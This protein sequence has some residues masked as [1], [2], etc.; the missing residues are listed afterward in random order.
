MQLD[1][2][3]LRLLDELIRQ[4]LVLLIDRGERAGVCNVLIRFQRAVFADG[5]GI[6]AGEDTETDRD[7]IA[8]RPALN[9]AVDQLAIG[10]SEADGAQ[11]HVFQCCGRQDIAPA[12][13]TAA[14][15][16]LRLICGRDR[17]NVDALQPVGVRKIRGGELIFRGIIDGDLRCQRRDA[18]HDQNQRC[19]QRGAK[20]ADAVF[21]RENLLHDVTEV[22]SASGGKICKQIE[23]IPPESPEGSNRK[24]LGIK[25]VDRRD[26]LLQNRA[27]RL[28]L[29]LRT[30]CRAVAAAA[31]L[32][33]NGL[34]IARA[35]GTRADNDLLAVREEYK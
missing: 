12:D 27:Q 9:R 29:D 5:C 24:R 22:V 6:C 35:D 7:G 1:R 10:V 23:K 28:S 2:A 32:F 8:E 19:G 15:A 33:Q 14:D 20:Q 34:H 16:Q 18:E 11:L 25:S 26:K 31:E 21:Q 30:G 4:L 17:G 13:Y 3:A